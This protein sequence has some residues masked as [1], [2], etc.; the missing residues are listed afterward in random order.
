MFLGFHILEAIIAVT[1]PAEVIK[2]H[3]HGNEN[4]V[5]KDLTVLNFFVMKML[6]GAV[7]SHC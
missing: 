1:G 7:W 6:A 5:K 4:A 2:V 3:L